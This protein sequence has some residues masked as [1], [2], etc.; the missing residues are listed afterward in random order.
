MNTPF[1][2]L[3][4]PTSEHTQCTAL[5]SR[6][7]TTDTIEETGEE[8]D[9][10]LQ[11]PHSS[12][13]ETPST[14]TSMGLYMEH[15]G[16]L[17]SRSR[18]MDRDSRDSVLEVKQTGWERGP[19]YVHHSEL[20]LYQADLSSTIPTDT[21]IPPSY[22]RAT[23]LDREGAEQVSSSRTHH[24][25]R[26]VVVTPDEKSDFLSGITSTTFPSLTHELTASDLLRN[27]YCI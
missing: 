12:Y 27:R 10:D 6:Q 11:D 23:G 4:L 24:G 13:T 16:V 1:S 26:L 7:G 22:S 25:K 20:Q 15:E 9:Q 18:G 8:P 3:S 19:C 5:C 2:C 17:L 21:D 14:S